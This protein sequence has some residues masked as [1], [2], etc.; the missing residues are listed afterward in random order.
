MHRHEARDL[1][2]ISITQLQADQIKEAADLHKAAFAGYLNARIGDAYV[3]AFFA[4]VSARQD[5]DRFVRCHGRLAR[6]WG[7]WWALR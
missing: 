2:M 3:G 6:S 1:E 4:L 5:R 7:M